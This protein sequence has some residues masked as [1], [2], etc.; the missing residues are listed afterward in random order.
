MIARSFRRTAALA[1]SFALAMTL[2]FLAPPAY[3]DEADDLAADIAQETAA[4]EDAQD[5]ASDL[6]DNPSESDLDALTQ[7][8]DDGA[9]VTTR[10]FSGIDSSASVQLAFAQLQMQSAQQK[11]DQA[12]ELTQ[13]IQAKQQENAALSAAVD[14]LTELKKKLAAG[15]TSPLPADLAKTLADAGVS[16][17][18]AK[19]TKG[20]T[21]DELVTIIALATAA[22]DSAANDLQRDMVFL[23]DYI[24][25]YSS[26]TQAASNAMQQASDVL[27]GAAQRATVSAQASDGGF[28]LL[29]LAVGVAVVAGAAAGALAAYVLVRKRFE[30]G[31]DAAKAE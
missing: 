15:A 13:K 7:A 20:Y 14:E 4:A 24:G 26:Y 3:A 25:Q 6:A 8:L 28:S 30:T 10:S 18:D 16:V 27:K 23:Q 17:P 5:A 2:A 11:R 31:K 22:A 19:S 29:A 9:E 21:A 1:F 12:L